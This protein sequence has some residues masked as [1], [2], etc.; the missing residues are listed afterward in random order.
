LLHAIG[1][2]ELVTDSALDYERL[3]CELISDSKRLADVREKLAFNRDRT[4]LF[5]TQATTREL[6]RIFM[7]LH[8]SAVTAQVA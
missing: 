1:L 8:W 3:V 6:E 4:P 2:P 7:H 5:D